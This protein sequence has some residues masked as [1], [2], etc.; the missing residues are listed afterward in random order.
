MP[1]ICYIHYIKQIGMKLILAW[2]YLEF[3]ILFVT[4]VE[5]TVEWGMSIR[6]LVSLPSILRSPMN[7]AWVMLWDQVNLHCR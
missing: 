1:L 4:L 2:N 3:T 6:E 7:N 5:A